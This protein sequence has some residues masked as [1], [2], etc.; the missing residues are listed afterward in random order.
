ML[1][2]GDTLLMQGEVR[3]GCWWVHPGAG[4]VYAARGDVCLGLQ[5]L[6]SLFSARQ[7]FILRWESVEKSMIMLRT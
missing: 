7:S 3:W 5:G 4:L 6:I 1:H 2:E